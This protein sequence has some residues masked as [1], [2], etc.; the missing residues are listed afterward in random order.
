MKTLCQTDWNKVGFYATLVYRAIALLFQS[1]MGNKPYFL[2]IYASGIFSCTH[3]CTGVQFNWHKDRIEYRI[4]REHQKSYLGLQLKNCNVGN[5]KV[6]WTTKTEMVHP[7]DIHGDRF[8]KG[9]WKITF[10]RLF[11]LSYCNASTYQW[12][13]IFSPFGPVLSQPQLVTPF[14]SHPYNFFT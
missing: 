4:V 10:M 3:C 6:S 5:Q 11:I 2:R 7:T 13:M 9:K 8:K 1:D 14:G 12:S